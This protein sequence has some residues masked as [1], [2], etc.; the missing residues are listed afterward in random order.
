MVT[1]ESHGLAEPCFSLVTTRATLTI[2]G[3]SPVTLEIMEF[4]LQC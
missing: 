3:F 1:N 4:G 2:R